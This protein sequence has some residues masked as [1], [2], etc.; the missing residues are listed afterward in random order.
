MTPSISSSGVFG[1]VVHVEHQSGVVSA[2]T[3]AV[4]PV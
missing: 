3:D 1:G 2:E 4:H